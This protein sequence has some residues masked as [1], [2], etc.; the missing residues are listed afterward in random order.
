MVRAEHQTGPAQHDEADQQPPDEHRLPIAGVVVVQKD[1]EAGAA[2][3]FGRARR[4]LAQ[5][6]PVDRTMAS[7]TAATAASAA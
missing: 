4:S 3:R 7:A 5:A 2:R 1:G 6:A